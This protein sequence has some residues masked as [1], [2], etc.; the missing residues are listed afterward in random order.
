MRMRFIGEYT[1]G[2]ATITYLG[3]EFKGHEPREVPQDVADLLRG[4]P[5][6]EAVR[7]RK[8]GVKANG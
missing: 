4:P 8:P 3:C 5:E 1:N 2:R 7:G 6:F